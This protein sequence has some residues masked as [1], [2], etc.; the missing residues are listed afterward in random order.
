M[1]TF[2]GPI[3]LN[4]R[5]A[6]GVPLLANGDPGPCRRS[7][8]PSDATTS[9]AATPAISGR[10]GNLGLP[11]AIRVGLWATAGELATAVRL[12]LPR[13]DSCC[14]AR[15]ESGCCADAGTISVGLRAG[16]ACAGCAGRTGI[17]GC[18]AVAVLE[19]PS[20][21]SRLSR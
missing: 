3:A 18:G 20:A 7:K 8:A 11:G 5:V 6:V 14:G 2:H 19:M 1:V 17:A 12:I 16:W 4:V 13:N 21:A 15:A 9:N 10:R